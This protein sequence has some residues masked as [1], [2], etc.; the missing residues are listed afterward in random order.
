MSRSGFSTAHFSPC[1]ASQFVICIWNSDN[2]VQICF[3]YTFIQLLASTSEQCKQ[4]DGNTCSYLNHYRCSVYVCVNALI[5]DSAKKRA[6]GRLQCLTNISKIWQKHKELYRLH[7]WDVFI[8]PAAKCIDGS[9]F[10]IVNH[11]RVTENAVFSMYT[12]HTYI[13]TYKYC[14]KD[15]LTQKCI[16]SCYQLIP[17]D[18]SR[19][20]AKFPCYQSYCWTNKWII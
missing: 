3:V 9:N 13:H 18:D 15:K 2:I 7:R 20:G 14:L 4:N 12:I 19:S 8:R 11:E 1:L 16:F 6:E 10:T 17:L 5:L